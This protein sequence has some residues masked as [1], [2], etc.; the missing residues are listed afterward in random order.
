MITLGFD[1][2][3]AFK[4]FSGLGNYSR[5]LIRALFTYCPQ[6]RYILYTPPYSAH[7]A[8]EQLDY[9]NVEVKTPKGIG[10]WIPQWWRSGG[11]GFSTALKTEGVQV[12][13]GL[14]AE[15]PCGISPSVAMA[16]TVHDLIFIR[17]PQYYKPVD[18]FVYKKKLLYACQRANIVI[19]V[20]QQTRDDLIH[21]LHVDP[22]KIV[23]LYQGCDPQFYPKPPPQTCI[24][25]KAKYHLPEQYIL[26][27]GTIEE[28]K[29]L[30]TLIKSLTMLPQ[31]IH[32]VAVGKSTSY[33]EQVLREVDKQKIAPRVHFIHNTPFSD[34]PALYAGA[35]ALV[36]PSLF[37]G[38][39]IPV[40]E[41]LNMG[42]PVITS[43]IS[44]MPE[45]GGDAA[46]YI[47]PLDACEMAQTILHILEDPSLSAQM[48]ERGYR[49]ALHFRE[50]K[51][52]FAMNALYTK[53]I[54]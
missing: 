35:R 48:V 27:V 49:H 34:L 14:S 22:E 45:A 41:G 36:Y 46:A 31:S 50:D 20:S 25:V 17:Y 52:A 24:A 1:A 30:I 2:K 21:Y 37:E 33:M 29:N 6:N 16:V 42:I 54:T 10:H 39:G 18:R 8:L 47:N 12:F 40:L 11:L 53:L 51:I 26:S 44:S 28:R 4:N 3:R 7:P 15:L 43:N 23:V 38:F 32:L 19:A 13:H 9:P 5:S